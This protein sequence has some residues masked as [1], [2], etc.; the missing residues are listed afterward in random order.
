MKR[1]SIFDRKIYENGGGRYPQSHTQNCSVKRLPVNLCY[2]FLLCFRPETIVYLIFWDVVLLQYLQDTVTKVPG[3]YIM[4]S[5]YTGYS[6]E[7]AGVL[8]YLFYLYRLQ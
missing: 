6:N 3:V 1:S 8:Y 2:N 5:T 4:Y 7:G